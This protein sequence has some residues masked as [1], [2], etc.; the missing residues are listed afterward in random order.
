MKFILSLAVLFAIQ[1]TSVSFGQLT[2]KND[3]ILKTSG[4]ELTGKIQ[5]IGDTEIKFV[6]AGETLVYSIKKSDIAK[7]TFASGRIEM[8][9][10]PKSNSAK[11][12]SIAKSGLEAHQNKIAILPFSYLVNKQDAGQEMTYKVQNEVFNIMNQHSGYMTVQPTS[13]TNALLLKAGI[14]G[15]NVR[16]FTMGEICNVLGVEYVIQGTITQDLTS[17][18]SSTSGSTTYNTK[19]NTSSNRSVGTVSGA[20]SSYSSQNYTTNVTMAIYTDK[21]ETIFSQDHQSFWSSDD[22]YKTT[23]NYLLKR[24]PIYQK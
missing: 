16:S 7:I 22:A 11:A 6:Y 21:G 13:T 19:G 23:L 9:N 8:F 2:Q 20:S 24:T 3:V 14:T 12:D 4:D 5:E 15:A 17:V 1:M 10:S 18:S